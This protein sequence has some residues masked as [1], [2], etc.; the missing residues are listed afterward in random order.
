MVLQTGQS[1][2]A[3]SGWRIGRLG[4]I[5]RAGAA[6]GAFAASRHPPAPHVRG[7]FAKPGKAGGIFEKPRPPEKIPAFG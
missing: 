5:C 6:L 4:S 2:T 7:D 3:G 1:A